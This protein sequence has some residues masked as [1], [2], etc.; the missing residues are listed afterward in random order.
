L[1]RR[2]LGV[3]CSVKLGVREV[4]LLDCDAFRLASTV[5]IPVCSVL[6]AVLAEMYN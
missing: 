5:S 4:R 3:Q 6:L 2:H 1:L